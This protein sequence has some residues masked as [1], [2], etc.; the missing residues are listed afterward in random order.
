MKAAGV[1][2]VIPRVLNRFR[3]KAGWGQ[4]YAKSGLSNAVQVCEGS[5][6]EWSHGAQRSE[7]GELG[8]ANYLVLPGPLFA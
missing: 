6:I 2:L 7:V 1:M 4:G 8:G 5:Q 3:T